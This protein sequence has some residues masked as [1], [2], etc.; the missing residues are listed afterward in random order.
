MRY[1]QGKHG[2]RVTASV[3]LERPANSRV[4]DEDDFNQVHT[5]KLE[6]VTKCAEGTR[7]RVHM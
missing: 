2:T 6:Y 5:K 4:Y 3:A 1:T 7:V